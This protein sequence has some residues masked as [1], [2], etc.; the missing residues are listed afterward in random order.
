MLPRLSVVIPTRERLSTLGPCLQGC[1]RQD[2]ANF[3][4]VV[5]DNASTDGT[6]AY[7][8][9]LDDP[10]VRY[11]RTPQ[12]VSMRANFENGV[13]NARGDY[14][15]MIGDDDGL[16]PGG[17]AR[18][19]A[20]S[21]KGDYDFISWPDIWYHWPRHAGDIA[22]GVSLKRRDLFG[23]M[24]EVAGEDVAARLLDGN[25]TPWK[26]QP[27][28]YHGC[29]SA[30]V[31]NELKDKTGR[32][33]SYDVPDI[34]LQAA[35]SLVSRRGLILGHPV[36]MI[37]ISP[38]STGNSH[39]ATAT[40]APVDTKQQNPGMQFVTEMASDE[41]ARVPFNPKFISTDY[42]IYCCLVIARDAL[43][44]Q[45][46]VNHAAWRERVVKHITSQGPAHRLAKSAPALSTLD[47]ELIAAL[48]VVPERPIV[49]SE[50]STT[51]RVPKRSLSKLARKARLV[52]EKNAVVDD[53][54]TA[55]AALEAAGLAAHQ[56]RLATPAWQAEQLFQ[57]VKVLRRTWA[58]LVP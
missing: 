34:Y 42:Y 46:P 22:A 10:R 32:V 31:L 47:A 6:E 13:A 54:A 38:K 7:V 51:K 2:S 49:E 26:T 16:V 33:F 45:S 43:G 23:P 56:D 24:H 19:D 28:I 53:V 15:V 27:R 11:H 55:S 50:P 30:R 25:L 36:S 9:G 44:L 12:R 29:I 48:A 14:I 8:R 58:N 20:V 57:W 3:E 21:R 39:F 17:I 52:A 40:D 1:L 4:I 18:L 5:Q 37:G 41:R 35:A